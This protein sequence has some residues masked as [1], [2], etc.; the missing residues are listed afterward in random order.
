MGNLVGRSLAHFRIEA[1]LGE[2][3]MGVVYRATD[4]KLRRKVA[5]KVLHG[6]FAQDEDRRRRFL[7]EARSAAAVMHSNIAAVFDVGEADGH[8]YIA[9]E[10]VEGET[11]RARMDRGLSIDEAVSI[12]KEIATGLG[13]AHEKGIVHRDLKPENV[14]VTP[15]GEVKILD[16]G[17][18]K[19]REGADRSGRVEAGPKLT[20]EGRILGTPDYMSPEQAHGQAL[21]ARTDV[22]SFGV[23]FFEMLTGQRPFGGPTAMAVL[24]AAS[25]DIPK[26]PSELNPAVTPEVDLIVGRCLEKQAS[27]RYEDGQALVDALSVVLPDAH[28]TLS[29]GRRAPTTSTGSGRTLSGSPSAPKGRAQWPWGLVA[30]AGLAATGLALGYR[31]HRAGSTPPASSSASPRGSASGVPSS[32][33]ITLLDLPPPATTVLEAAHEYALGMGAYHDDN[34]IASLEHFER[35]VHL[36]PTMAAAHLRAAIAHYQSDASP[37]RI[38]AEFAR[39]TELRAGLSERDQALMNALEPALYRKRPDPGEALRRIEAMSRSEPLDVELYDWQAWL[40]GMLPDSLPAIERAIALDPGDANAWQSRG[41]ALGYSGKLDE[42]RES[43]ERCTALSLATSDC[44]GSEAWTDMLAGDCAAFERDARRTLDRSPTFGHPLLM[45]ALVARGRPEAAAREEGRLLTE[46]LPEGDRQLLVLG[47][48]AQ[49]ALI[50]G[51]FAGARTLLAREAPALAAHSK[52]RAARIPHY[53]LAMQEI[54]LALET[55]DAAGASQTAQDFIARSESWSPY[56]LFNNGVDLSAFIAHLAPGDFEAKRRALA[57]A[58]L[59]VGAYR[60]MVWVYAFA[61]PAS[62]PEEAR[63]ALD[64]M[65]AYEPIT[66]YVSSLWILFGDLGIPDA[67]IGHVYLLAG[68]PTEALPYLKRAVA[69]CMDFDAVYEHTRAALDLGQALEAT[70]DKPGACV[71]Y[72]RVLDRWGNAKPRSV[73]ADL[74]RTRVKALACA[75]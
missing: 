57:D 49:F 71:A 51:D 35:A 53:R 40:H 5:L 13:R 38:R 58:W 20:Q 31:T 62:T 28:T 2:G 67:A 15:R 59:S 12:A 24:L 74:A 21:D 75:L 17:V 48:D 55:G 32:S 7:R 26:R 73:T 56:L 33:A 8:V 23:L 50:A 65:P 1:E 41:I 37:E 64:A 34:G 22:F 14:M 27:G 6:S 43:F 68:K 36:D 19:L 30:L 11:L 10:L 72:K 25:Q 16:F 45:S 54:I 47:L 4:D 60:G 3:G 63:A 39:A 46:S 52:W 66:S 69:A 61:A 44:L 70:G 42:A 18:A 9:M 29:G